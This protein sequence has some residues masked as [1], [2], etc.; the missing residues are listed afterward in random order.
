MNLQ[1]QELTNK[2]FEICKNGTNNT[3]INNN[4]HILKITQID[5]CFYAFILI[6]IIFR[7]QGSAFS[8]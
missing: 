5:K 4:S 8:I 6:F 7:L 1:N 3:M 2:L